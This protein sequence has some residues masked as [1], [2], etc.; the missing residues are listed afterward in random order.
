MMKEAR[1]TDNMPKPRE[2]VEIVA[3][4]IQKVVKHKSGSFLD[5]REL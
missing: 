4:A 3:R 1:G 2:A 5:V